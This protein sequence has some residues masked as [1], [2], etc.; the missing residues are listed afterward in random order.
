MGALLSGVYAD[1]WIFAYE[2][3][4]ANLCGLWLYLNGG[5]QPGWK[6]K[7][8][9]Q[10][11][12]SGVD[13]KTPPWI[14]IAAW[15]EVLFH[16]LAH[17]HA[18]VLAGLLAERKRHLLKLGLAQFLKGNSQTLRLS[19]FALSTLLQTISRRV[20]ISGCVGI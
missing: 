20:V 15:A 10:G 6:T 18:D 7:Q 11:M 8:G 13:R 14:C 4:N 17:P 19:R 2:N 9:L 12:R 5:R 16:G 1:L 3:G